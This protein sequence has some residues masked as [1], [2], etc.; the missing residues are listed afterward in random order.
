MN[1]Y[2]VTLEITNCDG[3][4]RKFWSAVLKADSMKE[5]LTIAE[6]SLGGSFHR[7]LSCTLMV[8]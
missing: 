3:D 6:E 7:F 2:L 8:N 5:A 1:E 4:H